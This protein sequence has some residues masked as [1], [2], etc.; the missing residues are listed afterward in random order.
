MA[1]T[2]KKTPDMQEPALDEPKIEG[3]LTVLRE[4]GENARALAAQ[5][6]YQGA[7]TVD[8]LEDRIRIGQRR[9]IE[10][11]M[12]LGA[13]LMLLREITPHGEFEERSAAFGIDPRMARRLMSATLKFSNRVSKPVLEAAGSQTKLLELV[14]LD[15]DEIEALA[16]GDSVRG[17]KLDDV[18]TMSVRELRAALREANAEADATKKVL[19]DKNAKL[20]AERAKLRRIK[21]ATPDQVLKEITTEAG[22]IKHEIW[23]ALRAKLLPACEAL[24]DHGAEHGVETTLQMA[25]LVGELQAEL[26]A[27]RSQFGLPDLSDGV[28]QALAGEVAQ[29]GGSSAPAH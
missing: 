23:A 6:G 21:A 13:S 24:R 17:V 25:N 9:T 7:L 22:L 3:A 27:I 2:P 20:D 10:A 28:S 14:V 26:A 16:K 29:W 15:E 8:A 5:L 12:E 18:E 4:T 11:V 19:A 1:R